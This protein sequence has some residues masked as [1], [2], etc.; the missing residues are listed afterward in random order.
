MA[1]VSISDPID[2]MV[3]IG[4]LCIYFYV[5][6]TNCDPLI[7]IVNMFIDIHMNLKLYLRQLV[8]YCLDCNT[9]SLY[10]DYFMIFVSVTNN[11]CM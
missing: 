6:L 9:T 2:E 3:A 1:E 5:N 10:I 8:R 7:L 11:S 4:V